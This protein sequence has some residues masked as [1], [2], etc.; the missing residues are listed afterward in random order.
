MS[1]FLLTQRTFLSQILSFYIYVTSPLRDPFIWLS[2]LSLP[3]LNCPF[4][5]SFLLAIASELWYT[6]TQ[7]KRDISMSTYRSLVLGPHAGKR[8]RK[9]F[10]DEKGGNGSTNEPQTPRKF[11]K[12]QRSR[13]AFG[14]CSDR[15]W[16]VKPA[17]LPQV[18]VVF[19]SASNFYFILLI[20]CKIYNLLH[21]LQ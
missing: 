12:Q 9:A 8:A 13:L 16:A 11:T 7:P 14:M 6:R 1:Y 18:F 21:S 5:S 17:I 2:G 10:Q 15:I 4:F 20:Y 3:E 19:F